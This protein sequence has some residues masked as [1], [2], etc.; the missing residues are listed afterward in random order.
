MFEKN[1]L[2]NI[3]GMADT[4]DISEKELLSMSYKE[5]K[6]RLK[7]NIRVTEA[8]SSLI[9]EINLNRQDYD[10]INDS[11]KSISKKI[12]ENI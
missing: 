6:E 9:D 11:I 5:I 8:V 12:E 3:L 10:H 4:L 7:V 2:S 1:S